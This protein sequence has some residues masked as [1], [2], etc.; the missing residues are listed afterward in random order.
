MSGILPITDTP[1][2]GLLA[3]LVTKIRVQILCT[4]PNKC[5]IA[6][7]D[8]YLLAL[9]ALDTAATHLRLADHF[10]SRERA[11]ERLADISVRL[12]DGRPEHSIE[13]MV[14]T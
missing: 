3:S 4:E 1:E 6:S 5:G 13:I 8:H 2:L 7:E 14:A 11:N 12:N 10:A 9:Q